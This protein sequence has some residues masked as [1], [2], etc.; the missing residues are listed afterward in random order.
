MKINHMQLIHK[1]PKSIQGYTAYK[2]EKVRQLYSLNDLV[3]SYDQK[4]KQ[5]ST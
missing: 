4:T 1:T 3:H 5:M 2:C